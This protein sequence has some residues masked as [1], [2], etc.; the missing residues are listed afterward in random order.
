[1]TL[2]DRIEAAARASGPLSPELEAQLAEMRALELAGKPLTRAQ[3]MPPPASLAQR[4]AHEKRL[5]D[6]IREGSDDPRRIPLAKPRRGLHRRKRAEPSERYRRHLGELARRG[7]RACRP[8][9]VPNR[10]HRMVA[11]NQSDASAGAAGRLLEEM[12]RAYRETTVRE[13]CAGGRPLT[14]VQA[15]TTV[16]I[17]WFWLKMGRATSRRGFA[18]VVDNI[19]MGTVRAVVRNPVTGQPYSRAGLCA[20]SWGKNRREDHHSGAM[21]RLRRAGLIFRIQPPAGVVPLAL[22]GPSGYAFAQT[23]I[24]ERSLYGDPPDDGAQAPP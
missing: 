21:A 13:A 10:V 19:P 18:L 23:W 24:S 6:A 11:W 9:E 3:V 8:G 12:P 7:A 2:A 1:M 16:S 5:D 22:V 15:R 20:T 17:A 14:H 4:R